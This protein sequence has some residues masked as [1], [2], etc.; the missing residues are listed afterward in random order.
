MDWT[1]TLETLWA[2]LN[3]PAGIT[4]MASALLWMLNKIY[5]AKPLWQQ[6]EGA[7][8][9]AVKFAEKAIPDD[10][11]NKSVARLDT[12]L[13]YFLQVYESSQGRKATEK[14]ISDLT[15]GLQIVHAKLEAGDQL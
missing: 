15:N 14:E 6:Y 10:T 12:A 1:N 8:I 4:V 5:A 3:S 7:L 9:S 13:R 2:V 11:P